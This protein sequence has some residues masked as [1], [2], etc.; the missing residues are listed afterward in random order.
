MI[1]YLNKLCCK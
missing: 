1:Y